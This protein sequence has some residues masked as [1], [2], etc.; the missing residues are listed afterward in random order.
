[1]VTSAFLDEL[2]SLKHKILIDWT[3]MAY[4]S[5]VLHFKML[6]DG[7]Y[8]A[9]THALVMV[10]LTIFMVFTASLHADS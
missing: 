10:C 9:I 7:C 1:V 6:K 2:N 5:G 4:Y 8:I 3:Q